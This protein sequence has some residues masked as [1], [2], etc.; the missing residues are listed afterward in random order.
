[1]TE[2]QEWCALRGLTISIEKTKYMVFHKAHDFRVGKVDPIMIK[3]EVIERVFS[4]KYLGVHLDPTLSFDLHYN[5]VASRLNGALSK[6]LVIKRFVNHSIIK[7][8]LNAY[9]NSIIDF[10]LVI[11]AVQ[12][13]RLLDKLTQKICNFLFCVNYSRAVRRCKNKQYKFNSVKKFSC[14][15][16]LSQYGLFTVS[17][18]V[19]IQLANLIIN[20]LYPEWFNFSQRGLALPWPKIVAPVF[21]SV[22]Y[23]RSI[24]YRGFKFWSSLPR[25]TTNYNE[26]SGNGRLEEV[27]NV[28]INRSKIYLY[29]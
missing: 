11:W 1:L 9:V 29:Y 16:M 14:N 26:L 13:D 23:K 22:T 10:C 19:N 18:S 15:E 17:E 5:H 8:L 7:L 20:N 21:N 3:G 24:R 4:F 27:K 12:N 2:L 25:L 28:I 6:L